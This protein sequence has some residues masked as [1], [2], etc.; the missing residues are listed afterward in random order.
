MAK[1]ISASVGKGGKNKPED[2][3]VIQELLN[4]FAGQVGFA[5]MKVDGAPNPKLDKAI[6]AFQL[7]VCGFKPDSRV[8]PGKR[9]MQ[10]LVA[11]P[12]KAKAEQKKDEAKVQQIKTAE[13]QKALAKVK[14]DMEAA[15]KAQKVDSSSWG[16]LWKSIST[17]AEELFESYWASDEKKGNVASPDAAQKQVK[18]ITDQMNKDVKKKIDDKIKEIDTGGSV[19]PGKITG[20]S[21]GVKK[22]LLDALYAVSSHYEGT[23]IHVT[24]GLRDKNSQAKAMFKYWDKH[25]KKDGKNGGIYW[26]LRQAKYQELWKEL[27]DFH[28]AKNQAGFVKCMMQKAPWGSVSRHLS[29][30][31]VDI[32]LQTDKKILEALKMVFGHYLAEKDGN[33][34]GIKC[35]HFDNKK[36]IK[37]VDDKL[38]A[39]FPA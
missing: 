34:E 21:S 15:A 23:A 17:Q 39:K 32:S 8:D 26:F 38:K 12:G 18:K 10:K 35:H 1:K 6:G 22:P 33:S 37:K 13:Q 9:T 31:A 36:G 7:N 30:E 2:I 27:D 29:G 24:S 16:D 19:F 4:P 14:K 3:K 20:K 28:A 25:L 11:G 5:K